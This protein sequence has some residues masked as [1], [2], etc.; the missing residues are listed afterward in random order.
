MIKKYVVLISFLFA[1][2][3]H[4]NTMAISLNQTIKPFS[5]QDITTGKSM[6][7]TDIIGEK[8]VR[9]SLTGKEW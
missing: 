5:G 3:L 7:M 1:F 9:S 2:F 8:P 4:I 6:D